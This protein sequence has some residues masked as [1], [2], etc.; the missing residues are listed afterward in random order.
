MAILS[1]ALF[2]TKYKIITGYKSA[3]EAKLAI[4]KGE[5][6]GVFSNSWSALKQQAPTWVSEKKVRIIIQHG[7]KRHAQLPDVPLLIDQSKGDED[8]QLLGLMLARQEASKP[9]LA[10]PDIPAD[11][12]VLLRNAFNATVKDEKFLALTTKASLPI[13]SPLTGEEVVAL[14]AQLSKTP[15]TVIKRMDD[16][17]DKFKAAQ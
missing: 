15:D 2:G 8:R 7:A 12:L 11:R 10:P 1:N 5:V 3:P 4:E 16:I 6:D 9:Y 14:T 13:D 17:F